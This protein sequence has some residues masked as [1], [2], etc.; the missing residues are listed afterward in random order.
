M[1]MVLQALADSERRAVFE[2]RRDHDATAADLLR[3]TRRVEPMAAHE[4]MAVR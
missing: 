4:G 1:D 3:R 2:I